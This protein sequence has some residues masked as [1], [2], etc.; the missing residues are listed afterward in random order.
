MVGDVIWI[1]AIE[2][3]KVDGNGVLVVRRTGTRRS[4]IRMSRHE[5]RKAVEHGKRLLDEADIMERQRIAEL[6]GL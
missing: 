1:D 6:R 4:V 5:F 2:S 3:I